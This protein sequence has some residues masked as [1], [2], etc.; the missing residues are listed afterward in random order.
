MPPMFS[1]DRR[2]LQRTV[3]LRGTAKPARSHLRPDGMD[4]PVSCVM[5]SPT[6]RI[7]LRRRGD[8]DVTEGAE[9][10]R[11]VD[12]GGG[13]TEPC[14]GG[15]EGRTPRARW[16][17]GRN[18]MSGK[19][20]QYRCGRSPTGRPTAN[21]SKRQSTALLKPPPSIRHDGLRADWREVCCR[22]LRLTDDVR[23]RP[24]LHKR[25]N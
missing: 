18:F 20:Q 10:E 11:F 7:A 9:A 13:Y 6:K 21:S 2:A 19:W 14:S 23:P 5:H 4:K 1:P 25:L 16:C 3:P 22:P 24:L 12:G 15:A 8:V 17:V